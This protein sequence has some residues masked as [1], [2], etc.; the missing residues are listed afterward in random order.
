MRKDRAL[1]VVVGALVVLTLVGGVVSGCQSGGADDSR[2]K[3]S[4]SYRY[5]D[6]ADIDTR[7]TTA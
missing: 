2:R 4:G 1:V 5:A 3:Q 7:W 6:G